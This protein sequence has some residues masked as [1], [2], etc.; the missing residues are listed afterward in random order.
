MPTID[1]LIGQAEDVERAA[2][3]TIAEHTAEVRAIAAKMQAA[4]QER[5]TAAQNAYVTRL[6]EQTKAA[7]AD[8]AG[9]Q[10]RLKELR[11]VRAEED[12]V[13]RLMAQRSPAPG[14]PGGAGRDETYRIG[15][16]D[17][18]G[19]GVDG[20]A[21]WVRSTDG[22]PAVV[23]RG[24]RFADHHVVRQYAAARHHAEQAII[25]QHGG[26]GQQVRA[27]ATTGGGQ[28]VVPTEWA[29]QIIDRARNLAAVLQAGAQIVPMDAKTVQI[30][31]LT[32]DPTAGFRT[33]GSAITASDPTFDNVTLDAKTLS[34]LT[35]GSME[36]FQ[37][38][39][40]AD[41]LVEEAIAQAIALQLDLVG[42]Y[43]GVTSGA[44]TINLPYPNPNPRGVLATLQALAPTSVLGTAA[45]NGTVQT[46]ATFWSEIID[47]IYTPRDNN[48]SP[49]ALLWNSKAAR[50]YAK[51]TDTTGQPLAVPPDIQQMARLTTNQIPSYT[52]GTGLNMTDVFVGRWPLLLIGQ[53][54]SL[55]IQVLTER[56]AEQGQIGIVA[57]WR[58]DVAL[59]RPR[60]FAVFQAIQGA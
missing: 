12:E 40:N 56:Y 24:E 28:A 1:E 53:R 5:L 52:K 20:P 11:T 47:T 59:A 2:E 17:G 60:A 51:A 55:E 32:G 22:K 58:G 23:E 30:G 41:E 14:M 19:R 27:L 33:E 4:G 43:G 8:R 37:D 49:N 6:M 13:Q 45:T 9:A 26:I 10:A 48:E 38:A 3:R 16:T 35:I 54:L 57:H 29:G 18:Q 25:G 21:R 46:A 36:W 7:Q 44:G 50:K 34:A 42:L 31:R 39:V 15:T